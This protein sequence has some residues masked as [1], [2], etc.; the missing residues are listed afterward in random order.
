[1][2]TR[3]NARIWAVLC[4]VLIVEGRLGSVP[5]PGALTAAGEPAGGQ[6]DPPGCGEWLSLW[7]PVLG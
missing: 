6:M 5:V 1:M 7:V 2:G 4:G 3:G